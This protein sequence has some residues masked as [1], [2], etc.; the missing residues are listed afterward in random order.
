MKR[1]FLIALQEKLVAK[2]K[3][4][5]AC[6]ETGGPDAE[7]RMEFS[8]SWNQA[9]IDNLNKQGIQGMTDEETVQTFFIATQMIPESMMDDD[10]VNPAEMPGLTSEA[11]TLRR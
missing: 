11:N 5:W 9:F 10:A 2:S 4:P 6:F 1:K 7:G 3:K 8:I